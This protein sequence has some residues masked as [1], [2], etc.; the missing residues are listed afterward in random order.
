MERTDMSTTKPTGDTEV[1][2]KTGHA[3]QT[4]ENY[5]CIGNTMD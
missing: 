3:R 1:I 4:C 2:S 5:F